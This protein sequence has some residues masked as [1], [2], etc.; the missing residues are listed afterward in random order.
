MQ[1]RALLLTL[2]VAV[3]IAV[4]SLV[5]VR[6]REARASEL[7]RSAQE[8]LE[9]DLVEAPSLDRLQAATAVS[10][11]ERAEA[12]AWRRDPALAGALHY[13]R[14]LEQ[15]QRGDYVRARSELDAARHLLGD[16]SPELWVLSASIHRAM[17]QSERAESN[18][19]RALA[20]DGT[21]ARALML[22]GDLAIDRGD[23]PK[24]VTLLERLVAKAGEAS[25]AHDRLG[26]AYELVGRFEDAEAQFRDATARNQRDVAA[27]INLGRAVGRRGD[28]AGSLASFERALG[29]SPGD[30]QAWLGKCLAVAGLGRLEAAEADCTRAAE[31][32][33]GDPAPH[34]ALGDV[35]RARGDLPAAIDAYREAIARR[36]SD[37]LAWLKLGNV[38]VASADLRGAETAYREAIARLPTLGAAH[39]GLGAALMHQGRIGEAREEL[40]RAADLDPLDPNP[41]LN[42]GLLA[43]RQGD[44]AAAREAYEQALARD[45]DSDVAREK[46]LRR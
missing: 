6:Q 4:A 36:E 11:L 15:Y 34:L 26:L 14:A 8:R 12:L 23:G 17:H 27:L 32:D 46:L 10:R 2:S 22:A 45:P 43:E 13:A 25:V 40:E 9:A 24:A 18:V 35:R 39:N 41:F 16:R 30:P 38:L 7:I 44:G 42:L 28:L 5:F 37:P 1:R 20:L 33:T 31:L 29:L 19:E 21:H 3:L